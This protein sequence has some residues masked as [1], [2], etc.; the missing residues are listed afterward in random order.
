MQ[1]NRIITTAVAGGLPIGAASFGYAVAQFVSYP[2]HAYGV[3]GDPTAAGDGANTVSF[4][5]SGPGGYEYI[6]PMPGH[7]QMGMHGSFTVR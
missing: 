2:G 3:I 4:T 5:V 6:C 1:R 7:A